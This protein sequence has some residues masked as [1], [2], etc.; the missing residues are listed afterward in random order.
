MALASG[1]Y[2]SRIGCSSSGSKTPLVWSTTAY[3]VQKEIQF[4]QN[5]TYENNVQ[6]REQHREHAT[7]DGSRDQKIDEF[8]RSKYDVINFLIALAVESTGRT[9]TY[10]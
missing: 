5:P 4:N 8:V 2:I 3:P 9:G 1:T 7:I 6:Q 10:D